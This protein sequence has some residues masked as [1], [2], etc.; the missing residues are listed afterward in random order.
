L[1]QG[2]IMTLIIGYCSEWSHLL[3]SLPMDKVKVMRIKVR[4]HL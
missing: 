1:D 3:F 2:T 4:T